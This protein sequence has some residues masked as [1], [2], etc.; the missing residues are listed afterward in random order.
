MLDDQSNTSL[1]KTAFDLSN[2]QWN[3]LP[4]TMRTSP[5]LLGTE[6]MTVI[7]NMMEKVSI[8][9]PKLSDQIT[10]T[11]CPLLRRHQVTLTCS[12]SHLSFLHWIQ[13]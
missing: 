3:I 2:V 7:E 12:Q 4:Y 10:G 9:L 8:L 1:A 5:R 6:L 13:Q 11:R